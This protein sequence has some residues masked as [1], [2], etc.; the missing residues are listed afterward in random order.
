M[1]KKLPT[2]A[3]LETM[4]EKEGGIEI[5]TDGTVSV[6]PCD[7]P[8]CAS[9]RAEVECLKNV[10]KGDEDQLR[11]VVDQNAALRDALIAAHQGGELKEQSIRADW[12]RDVKVWED[13]Y[14]AL[15]AR[16]AVLEKAVEWAR[17]RFYWKQDREGETTMQNVLN[18][19]AKEG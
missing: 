18:R 15:R 11:R 2:I 12:E 13:K 5:S 7:R 14:G 8:S 9:L 1:D 6:K 10:L 4:I 3:E 17:D 19:R 16:I